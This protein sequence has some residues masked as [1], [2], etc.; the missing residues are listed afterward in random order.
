M[1]H[2]AIIGAER[3]DVFFL[4][5]AVHV[6]PLWASGNTAIGMGASGAA[7]QMVAAKAR[8]G[9]MLQTLGEHGCRGV[10][11]PG[12]GGGGASEGRC[13]ASSIGRR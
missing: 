4:R 2:G 7:L 1:H 13:L 3:Q 5:V 11:P 12:A 10:G 8:G 9:V 6:G